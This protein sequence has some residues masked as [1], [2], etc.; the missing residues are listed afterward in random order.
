M[1][2][3]FIYGPPAVGKLTVTKEL[4]KITGYKNFHN[5]LTL[6]AVMT[7]FEWGD[8]AGFDLIHKFRLD[9]M[10]A[11]AKHKIPGMIFTLVYES[12]GDNAFVRNVV[13]AVERHNGKVLFVQLK[14]DERTLLKRVSHASRKKFGKIRQA[15]RLKRLL[16]RDM[17]SSVPYK[18]NLVI[19]TARIPAKQAARKIKRHY[20]L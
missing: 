10:E 4:A 19:D 9:L 1:N 11:A 3:I 13:R 2:L 8:K 6:D 7:V 17:F 18:N 12:P 14:C 16:H 15:S 20:K 5:Q